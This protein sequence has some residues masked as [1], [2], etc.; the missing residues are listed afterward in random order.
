[1]KPLE[2][3]CPLCACA[4]IDEVETGVT[5]Y[6]EV[7]VYPDGDLKY[8]EEECVREKIQTHYACRGCR[9]TLGR[10]TDGKS[11]A[12]WVNLNCTFSIETIRSK[13]G[14]SEQQ[15]QEIRSIIFDLEPLRHEGNRISTA[16]RKLSKVGVMC[17]SPEPFSVIRAISGIFD[18]SYPIPKLYPKFIVPASSSPQ[19]IAYHRKGEYYFW[20]TKEEL[21]EMEAKWIKKNWS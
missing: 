7:E 17:F 2:F 4:F 10:V 8:E 12:E 9:M 19:K 16:E 11:L 6:N 3:K 13:L 15:A 21:S 5:S 14:V 1:M 20:A 18:M